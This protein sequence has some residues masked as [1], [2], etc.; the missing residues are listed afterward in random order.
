MYPHLS[1]LVKRKLPVNINKG[2]VNLLGD[3]E[4]DGGTAMK[5]KEDKNLPSDLQTR[6]YSVMAMISFY[7]LCTISSKEAFPLPA[8]LLA[9]T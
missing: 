5:R 1:E 6:L 9:T 8:T 3:V 2:D 7:L 4:E